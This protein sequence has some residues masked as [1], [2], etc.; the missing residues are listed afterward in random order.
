MR[1]DFNDFLSARRIV[2]REHDH[3]VAAL[4]VRFEGRV[5]AHRR[6]ACN[7]DPRRPAL[8][9]AIIFESAQSQVGVFLTR[10]GIVFK[11]SIYRFKSPRV[12]KPPPAGEPLTECKNR[13]FCNTFALYGFFERFWVYPRARFG[14]I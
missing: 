1:M 14:T 13:L 4:K 7:A 11:A 3:G 2:V 8:P 6:A 10:Q 9:T 12:E 5:D